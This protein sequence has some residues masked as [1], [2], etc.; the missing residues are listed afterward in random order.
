MWVPG[1]VN[2]ADWEGQEVP[3]APD[4]SLGQTPEHID[5]DLGEVAAAGL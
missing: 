5:G 4:P 3:K 1:G 2:V